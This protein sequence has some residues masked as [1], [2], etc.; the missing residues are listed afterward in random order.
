MAAAAAVSALVV[1]SGSIGSAAGGA[2]GTASAGVAALAAVAGGRAASGLGASRK[3]H[4]ATAP[5]PPTASTSATMEIP[6][7]NDRGPERPDR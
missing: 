1:G 3:R 5:A 6:N 7:T 2:T 4:Q